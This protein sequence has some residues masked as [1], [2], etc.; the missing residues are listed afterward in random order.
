MKIMLNP[1]QGSKSNY[2]IGAVEKLKFHLVREQTSPGTQ[3]VEYLFTTSLKERLRH[4]Y[5]LRPL[6]TSQVSDMIM[7]LKV[8]FYGLLRTIYRCQIPQD[9]N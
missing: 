8:L 2:A 3:F 4:K 6:F 1:L 5:V 7:R 9:I